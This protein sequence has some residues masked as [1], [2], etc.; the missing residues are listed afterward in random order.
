MQVRRV[1]ETPDRVFE[2]LLADGFTWANS[3]KDLE[4]LPCLFPRALSC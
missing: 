1:P 4:V 3:S 2:V